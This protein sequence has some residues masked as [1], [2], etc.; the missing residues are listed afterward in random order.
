MGQ[1]V[2]THTHTYIPLTSRQ[3]CQLDLE[4]H[5]TT[6]TDS[7]SYLTARDSHEEV[8]SRTHTH[9]HTK[10]AA[11]IDKLSIERT[12]KRKSSRKQNHKSKWTEEQALDAS[13]QRSLVHEKNT[14]RER[15]HWTPVGALRTHVTLSRETA[16]KLGA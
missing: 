5:R 2:P 8:N 12:T 11:Q 10:T 13:R 7:G 14:G 1:D 16:R 6:N 15:P 4:L 9:K 3:H